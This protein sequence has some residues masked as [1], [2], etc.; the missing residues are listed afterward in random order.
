MHRDWKGS[1]VHDTVGRKVERVK[2]RGERD[3]MEDEI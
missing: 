2:R 1:G 3:E